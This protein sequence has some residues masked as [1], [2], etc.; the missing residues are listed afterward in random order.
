MASQTALETLVA[1]FERVERLDLGRDA[2]GAMEQMRMAIRPRS[3]VSS[4]PQDVRRVVPRPE[5]LQ[6][7]VEDEVVVADGAVAV[8]LT[9]ATEALVEVRAHRDARLMGRAGGRGGLVHDHTTSDRLRGRRVVL[10]ERLGDE[11]IEDTQ[12]RLLRVGGAR[13]DPR[14]RE[15]DPPSPALRRALGRAPR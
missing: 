11:L 14:E 3:E 12:P 7:R 9:D 15:S 8:R 1:Y 6:R 2:R 13:R 4:D 5:Q 10:V